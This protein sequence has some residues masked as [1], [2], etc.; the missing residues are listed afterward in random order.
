MLICLWHS[1]LIF[2]PILGNNEKF[3]IVHDKAGKKWV[4][5]VKELIDIKEDSKELV[6]T[7]YATNT[8]EN[9]QGKAVLIVQLPSAD[10]EEVPAFSES[11]YTGEYKKDND[12]YVVELK[13]NIEVTSE[14][15]IGKIV[16][17]L[18]QTG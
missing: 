12:K 7:I 4:L 16:V 15:D 1:W 9:S 2:Q 14:S 17:T 13:K 18:V 10:A 5:K 3:D 11:S 6:T 8:D